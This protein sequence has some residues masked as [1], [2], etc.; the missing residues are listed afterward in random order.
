MPAASGDNLTWR[1]F[2]E[3]KLNLMDDGYPINNSVQPHEPSRFT[4]L[5][6]DS[7]Q[8]FHAQEQDALRQ[9]AR[10]TTELMNRLDALFERDT[11]PEPVRFG[12]DRYGFQ[13]VPIEEPVTRRTILENALQ[14]VMSDRNSNYGEPE[15]NFGIIAALWA[16][17]LERRLERR[18]PGDPILT[19]EDVSPLMVLMKLGRLAHS[20]YHQDSW[21]DIAGYAATGGEVA[22]IRDP[23]RRK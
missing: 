16:P 8:T 21:N 4:G 7:Y 9:Y 19:P 12:F 23:N 3:E 15:D 11:E 14:F 17:W 13:E 5:Y 2:Q 6:P 20:P 22:Y 10:D 18:N 1:G